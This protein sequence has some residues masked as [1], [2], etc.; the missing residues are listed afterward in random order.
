MGFGIPNVSA[1]CLLVIGVL[2]CRGQE[3]LGLWRKSP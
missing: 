1:V 3:I 2:V